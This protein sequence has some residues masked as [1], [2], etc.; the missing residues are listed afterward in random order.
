M[1]IIITFSFSFFLF[2]KICFIYFQREQKEKRKRGREISMCGCLSLAPYWGP[3]LQ[4]RHVPWLGIEWATL[5]FTVCHSIHWSTPAR[6]WWIL[7]KT[8]P[9]C[10]SSQRTSSWIYWSFELFFYSLCHLIL[11][12][13]WLFNSFYL[14]WVVFIVVRQVFVDIGLGRLF[15]MFLSFF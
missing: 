2:L 4:P 7:L 1:G 9:F 3:G 12:W 15:E 11:L 10:L 5:W 8:C 14:L 13:S 6:A